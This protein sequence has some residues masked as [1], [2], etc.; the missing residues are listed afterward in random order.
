MSVNI[1]CECPDENAIASLVAENFGIALVAHVDAV[2][3]NN[4][5]IIPLSDTQLTHTVY[6]GYLKDKYQIP[7]VKRF[8]Q[9]VKREGKAY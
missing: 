7:A 8:I 6:M 5:R 3:H 9:F 1:V 4:V 2:E